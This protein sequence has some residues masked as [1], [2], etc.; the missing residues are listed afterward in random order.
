M[1]RLLFAA[2]VLFFTTLISC[3]KDNSP[4]LNNTSKE[5]LKQCRG[6]GGGWDLTDTIP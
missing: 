2:L 3:E 4:K 6:C 5:S 1:K